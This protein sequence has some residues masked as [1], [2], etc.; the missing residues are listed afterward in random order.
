MNSLNICKVLRLVDSLRIGMVNHFSQEL[1]RVFCSIV[2]SW[3]F[4]LLLTG[5][6]SGNLELPSCFPPRP[7]FSHFLSLNK[8]PFHFSFTED[9]FSFKHSD[10][11]SWIMCSFF[12]LVDD[13]KSLQSD[14]SKLVSALSLYSEL[15]TFLTVPCCLRVYFNGMLKFRFLVWPRDVKID[16]LA[17]W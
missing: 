2:E 10:N 6:C 17:K 11:I 12:L 1:K 7:F 9:G 5:T 3:I 16:W 13:Q 8:T 14:M 4:L 15:Y